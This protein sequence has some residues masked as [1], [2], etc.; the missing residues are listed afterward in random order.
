[1]RAAFLL[2]QRIRL[3]HQAGLDPLPA[4]AGANRSD[5]ARLNEPDRRT[6]RAAFRLL[7][8]LQ[9]RLAMDDCL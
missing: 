3:E 1:M 7:R 6:L 8:D 2:I 4:N 5:P 9:S